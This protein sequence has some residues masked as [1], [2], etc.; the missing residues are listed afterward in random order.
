MKARILKFQAWGRCAR[1]GSPPPRHAP[2]GGWGRVLWQLALSCAPHDGSGRKCTHCL[3]I[4]KTSTFKL[5]PSQ[6]VLSAC[7]KANSW[8]QLS[9]FFKVL[10]CSFDRANDERS[11]SQGL[12]KVYNIWFSDVTGFQS[13]N[14]IQGHESII[15]RSLGFLTVLFPNLWFGCV[16]IFLF[17][18]GL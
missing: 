16:G 5:S 10:I 1:G 2:Q 18:E 3:L 7:G 12:R 4:S 8:L 6:H 13:K 14:F 17:V 15:R 11:F 9:D